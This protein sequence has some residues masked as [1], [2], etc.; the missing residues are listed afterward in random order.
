MMSS[1]EQLRWKEFRH[2]GFLVGAMAI[3]PS[4]AGLFYPDILQLVEFGL[5]SEE[6]LCFIDRDRLIQ[7]FTD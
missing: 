5:L 6:I 1:H 2:E 3:G 4:G 7:E